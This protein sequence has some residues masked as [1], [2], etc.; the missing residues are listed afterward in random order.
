MPVIAS[1]AMTGKKHFIYSLNHAK[2]R[3]YC[4]FIGI[5]IPQVGLGS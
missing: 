2:M 3:D 1:E 5:F 4:L